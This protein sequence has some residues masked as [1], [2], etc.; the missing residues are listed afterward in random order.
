MNKPIDYINCGDYVFL[1]KSPCDVEEGGKAD[2]ARL[3]G[4]CLYISDYINYKLISELNK[5]L[6]ANSRNQHGYYNSGVGFYNFSG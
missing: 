4:A 3:A 1:E 6:R 2:L 5:N